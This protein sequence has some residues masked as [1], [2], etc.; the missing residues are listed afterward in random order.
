MNRES[1]L[2]HDHFGFSALP[3]RPTLKWPGNE[4]VALCIFLHFEDWSLDLPGH[5]VSDP[6]FSQVAR[7]ASFDYLTQSWFEYGN[8]I[9]MSRILDALDRHLFRVTVAAGSSA[10]GRYPELVGEF[11]ARQYE[12][13]AH[14]EHANAML[15]SRLSAED[16]RKLISGC[17]DT[18]EKNCGTRPVGWC[19]PGF[20][21]SGRTPTI[22]GEAGLLYVADWSNDDQPYPMT[23]GGLVSI[24]YQA[25]L[26]DVELIYH[27]RMLPWHYPP[28]FL[29]AF[30]R[31]H[32]EGE[33]SGRFLGLHIHP[34]ILGKAYMVV[35]LEEIL[36]ALSRA[37]GVWSATASDVARHMRKTAFNSDSAVP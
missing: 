25:G 14:G 29:R 8:R 28:L 12:F 6:R 7:S 35:H 33:V 30:E 15:S 11:K 5:A 3:S 34:W 18:V 37:D 23:S 19:G 9:G 17:L 26:D 20:G 31:L 4:R 36:A 24:P 10:T 21:E 1:R 27:R 32:V 22:L 16:E 2:D 13:A